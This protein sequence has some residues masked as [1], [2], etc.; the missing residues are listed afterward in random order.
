[1]LFWYGYQ[2]L[3]LFSTKMNILPSTIFYGS[4]NRQKTKGIDKNSLSKPCFLLFSHE[5]KKNTF[6]LLVWS[7]VW[8]YCLWKRWEF[9]IPMSFIKWVTNIEQG[10][11]IY[12]IDQSTYMKFINFFNIYPFLFYILIYIYKWLRRD[13]FLHLCCCSYNFS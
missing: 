13:T 6:L 1:M 9:V 7:K 12:S 4:I 2:F 3:I 8:D 10:M 5:L 11:I